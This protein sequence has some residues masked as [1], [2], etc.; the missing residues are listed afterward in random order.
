MVD[1]RDRDALRFIWRSNKDEKFQDIQMNV[2][3]FGKVDSPCCCIWALNKTASHNIIK[4]VSRA[5][6][7]IADNFYMDEYLDSFHIVQV[8]IKIS[9]DVANAVS[10]GGFRLT[11]WISNDQQILKAIPSQEPS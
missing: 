3:L 4:I 5:E 1:L 8:A 6:E 9:N 2:H 10:E 7:T 11:K